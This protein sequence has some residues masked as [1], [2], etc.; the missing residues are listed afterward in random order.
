MLLWFLVS[1]P[2]IPTRYHSKREDGSN[3]YKNMSEQAEKSSANPTHCLTK[4]F[5]E[6]GLHPTDFTS[7]AHRASRC[8]RVLFCKKRMVLNK[9]DI[10]ARK[11]SIGKMHA[12]SSQRLTRHSQEKGTDTLYQASTRSAFLFFAFTFFINRVSYP[13]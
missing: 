13:L 10:R 1:Y 4:T 8:A 3:T 2:Q 12:F 9:Y 7:L 6:Y 5:F 11:P